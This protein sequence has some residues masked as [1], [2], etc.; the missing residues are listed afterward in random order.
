MKTKSPIQSS[1]LSFGDD[2]LSSLGAAW[3]K[4]LPFSIY[5]DHR[6]YNTV[7]LPCECDVIS[8]DAVMLNVAAEIQNCLCRMEHLCL[9]LAN[10]VFLA[11]VVVVVYRV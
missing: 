6:P 9:E 3:D 11:L 5:F 10:V 2:G 8:D 1:T 4:I 7:A